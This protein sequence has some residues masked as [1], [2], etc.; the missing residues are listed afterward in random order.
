M[1]NE[2]DPVFVFASVCL[3]PCRHPAPVVR[4]IVVMSVLCRQVDACTMQY[5]HTVKD[6]GR[7]FKRA[8]RMMLMILPRMSVREAMIETDGIPIW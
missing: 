3:Q 7:V 1:E 5:V 6:A 8:L 4:T 2:R